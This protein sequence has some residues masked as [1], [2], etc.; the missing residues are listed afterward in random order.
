MESCHSPSSCLETMFLQ[1]KPSCPNSWVSSHIKERKLTCLHLKQ[2]HIFLKTSFRFIA[3]LSRRCRETPDARCH[4]HPLR[5]SL[6]L[7]SDKLSDTLYHLWIPWTRRHHPESRACPGVHG[8]LCVL[9]VLA[10]LSQS[11]AIIIISLRILSALYKSSAVWPPQSLFLSLRLFFSQNATELEWYTRY[12]LP[13]V[14]FSLLKNKLSSVM[15]S[16]CRERG[17]I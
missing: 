16:G 1:I 2:K 11:V 6:H 7:L 10:T 14:T 17:Y 8:G 15:S 5:A 3:K 13:M 4:H 9:W 12:P